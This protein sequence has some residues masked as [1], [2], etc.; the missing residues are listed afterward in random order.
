L[1]EFVRCRVESTEDDYRVRSTGTQS[2]GALRSLSLGDGLIVG[3]AD[4]T[5]LEQGRRV[6]V[7]MLPG[8]AVGDTLPF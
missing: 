1:T 6:Q 8:T 4:A 7:M 3:P 5:V 2:S